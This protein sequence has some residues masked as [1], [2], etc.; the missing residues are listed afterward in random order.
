MG[1]S[2]GQFHRSSHHWPTDQ[3]CSAWSTRFTAASLSSPTLRRF[4]FSWA[5]AHS[6]SYCFLP[7]RPHSHLS[8]YWCVFRRQVAAKFMLSSTNWKESSK[9]KNQA[10]MLS[11][12]LPNHIAFYSSFLSTWDGSRG[13]LCISTS[14][15]FDIFC[16]TLLIPWHLEIMYLVDPYHITACLSNSHSK[17]AGIKHFSV[18]SYLCT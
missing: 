3:W 11:L 9:I 16:N 8:I 7:F 17:F 15:I 12:Q 6:H 1:L 4:H 10:E 2:S 14:C 18:N 13:S 5:S